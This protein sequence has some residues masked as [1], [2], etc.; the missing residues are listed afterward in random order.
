MKL[1]FL[2]CPFKK[3]KRY[4]M[5][6]LVNLSNTQLS[7]LNR[8]AQFAFVVIDVPLRCADVFV[9]GK[10]LYNTHVDALVCQFR[11]KLT[12][13]TVAACT[14]DTTHGVKAGKQVHNCL[15]TKPAAF[16]TKK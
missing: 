7:Q 10:C 2:T 14:L 16:Y 12:S 13:A 3:L 6:V 15:G 4:E 9:M 1:G 8:V 5:N 11:Q